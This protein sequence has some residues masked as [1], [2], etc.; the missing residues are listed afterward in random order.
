MKRMFSIVVSVTMLIAGSINAYAIAPPL[1]SNNS[2]SVLVASAEVNEYDILCAE[3]SSSPNGMNI[4][5]DSESIENTLLERA[6]MPI[7][8]LYAYGYDDNE[9]EIL[10]EYDGS[11]IEE[12][13]QLRAIMATMSCEIYRTSYDDS[14]A[15][16]R[17][18]W[19][20]DSAPL[21]SGSEIYDCVGCAW[22]GVDS[23]NGFHALRF[24]DKDS[25]CMIYYYDTSYDHYTVVDI[26]DAAVDS[27]VEA[28][29]SMSNTP[30]TWAKAGYMTVTV[31]EPITVN[32]L[33]YS[34]FVFAYGHAY[35]TATPG[36]SVSGS[37]VSVS[38]TPKAG[39]KPMFNGS[40]SIWTNGDV[41][42]GGD[43]T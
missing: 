42:F 7:E 1:M 40:I 17:F 19:D 3:S 35:L 20:W 41:R 15:S 16:V 23:T 24:Q 9:I 14:G 31:A 43:A 11:P 34:T 21:F 37:G 29:F 33:E 18:E 13:P 12:N 28:R 38:L 6:Q 30:T 8:T 26:D 22:I 32:D 25:E 39:T 36:F 2:N 10:K 27:Y 5:S 4:I